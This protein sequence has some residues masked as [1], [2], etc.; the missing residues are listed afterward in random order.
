MYLIF[1]KPGLRLKSR[2]YRKLFVSFSVRHLRGLIGTLSYNYVFGDV[3][4]TRTSRHNQT[5]SGSDS[6]PGTEKERSSAESASAAGG[7]KKGWENMDG[8]MTWKSAEVRGK[9]PWEWHRMQITLRTSQMK[10]KKRM[11]KAIL[12]PLEDTGPRCS[13]G[14]RA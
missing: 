1:S 12:T 2:L 9:K 5:L 10:K 4:A 3:L 11:G 13:A 7:K 14:S 6:P 8:M